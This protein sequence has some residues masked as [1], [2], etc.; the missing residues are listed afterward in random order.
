MGKQEG[1][2]IMTRDKNSVGYWLFVHVTDHP[3][4]V[5]LHY[6]FQT[7]QKLYLIL[8]FLNGGELFSLLEKE[9]ILL[10]NH[11]CFYL[12]EILLALGYLHKEGIIYRDLKP[13]NVLLDA[14]G[15]VKLTDFNL[16]KEFMDAGSVTKTFCGTVDFMAPEILTRSG[17]GLAADWWSFGAVMYNMLTGSPPYTAKNQ[18][19]KVEKILNKKLRFPRYVT[20]VAKDL[21]RKLLKHP[22]MKRLG[23]GPEDAEEIKRH[24]FFSHVNWDD[25]LAKRVQPPF[26][27]PVLS[28]DDVSQFDKF[29]NMAADVPD[30]A[31]D[32]CS[33]T[34]S[35]KHVF[36]GF[37]FSRH[38]F[39]DD[40]QNEP[41]FSSLV[42]ENKYSI[43]DLSVA[44]SSKRKRE[45]SSRHCKLPRYFSVQCF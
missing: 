6:A 40:R 39:S 34:D 30:I 18:K 28:D 42:L 10:E 27:R 26:E 41:N 3:F 19:A 24:Q 5:E 29:T 8:E 14:K 20:E 33:L 7:Q 16:A 31:T 37:S 12:S 21:M 23:S 13:E 45:S 4:I 11:A 1:F 35:Q 2:L 25:V 43:L 32:D 15:H 36:S 22:Y 44:S 17:H 38:S 9:N